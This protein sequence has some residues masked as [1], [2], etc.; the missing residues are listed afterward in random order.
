MSFYLDLQATASR[1]ITQ[2]GAV[3]S[4]SRTSD[5]AYNP[6]TGAVVTVTTSQSVMAVVFEYPAHMITGTLIRTG[7]RK[8]LIS[9]A[10]TTAP[11]PGDDLTWQGI[12]YKVVHA[13]TLGPSGVAVLYQLQVRK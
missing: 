8:A 1:L 13:L 2:F 11:I 10:R 7:D 9:A 5:G 6:I 3:A 4:I 12:A